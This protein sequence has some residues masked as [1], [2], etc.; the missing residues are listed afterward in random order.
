[1]RCDSHVVLSRGMTHKVAC[2]YIGEMTSES[3][4]VIWALCFS[5]VFAQV[6]AQASLFE[7]V[8][9]AVG[10]YAL[11]G[12]VNGRLSVLDTL[13]FMHDSLTVDTDYLLQDSLTVDT[14]FRFA[15]HLTADSDFRVAIR[16]TVDSD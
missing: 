11:A 10:G 7:M 1:M 12:I 9:R 16:L 13:Y 5:K 2:S 4:Q 3:R 8:W 6:Y 14:A 15:I